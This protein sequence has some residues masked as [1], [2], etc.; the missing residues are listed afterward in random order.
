MIKDD[1]HVHTLF[2]GDGKAPMEDVVTY[3]ISKGLDS[4][5]FTEHNDFGFP[6]FPDCPKDTF[7]LNPDSYLYDLLMMREKYGMRIKILFGIEIGLQPDVARENEI[8]A[9]SYDFDFIIG[10]THLV[11]KRDP[12]Y[13]TFY[14]GRSEGDALNEYF[15]E[16]LRNAKENNFYDVLGHLDYIVRYAPT[17]DQNYHADDYKDV[18]DEILKS[19][20]SRGKGIEVNS[21]PLRKGLSMPNPCEWILKRYKE[22]GGE[23]I[24]VGSDSHMG[25]DLAADFDKVDEL[26]KKVGFNY[27]SIFHKR[28]PS[29]KR[30]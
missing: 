28:N 23:I 29:F 3:G 24:T 6:G 14:E 22:L 21:S 11:K 12:Y 19:L 8:L 25:T 4:I 2:S 10:S 7:L 9:S 15:E 16:V 27:I 30:I 1:F 26:L 5:C 17:K 18:I 20:I 13:P